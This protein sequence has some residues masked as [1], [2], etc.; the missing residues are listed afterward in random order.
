MFLHRSWLSESQQR[1]QSCKYFY[2]TVNTEPQNEKRKH[3]ALW[4]HTTH[5]YNT[6]THTHTC[7]THN[8]VSI[9]AHCAGSGFSPVCDYAA[10]LVLR[11]QQE[12]AFHDPLT[13]YVTSWLH[14]PRACTLPAV[15]AC[16]CTWINELRRWEAWLCFYEGMLFVSMLTST[17]TNNT[18]RWTSG[19]H[20]KMLSWLR[21]Y[22]IEV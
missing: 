17:T 8:V 13:Y 1:W 11:S 2:V 10:V 9:S 22:V 14:S 15:H 12:H 3:L 16:V 20:L 18:C 21:L 6:H 5:T 19:L 7:N 4:G